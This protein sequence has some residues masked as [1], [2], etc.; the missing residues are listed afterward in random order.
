M[1]LK[2]HLHGD[3]E[4]AG[5]LLHALCMQ[6]SPQAPQVY[7]AVSPLPL[8]CPFLVSVSF[9]P[10]SPTHRVAEPALM[11]LERR[12]QFEGLKKETV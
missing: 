9:A 1:G 10:H 11:R 12:R 2:R 3:R 6:L 5:G 7:A 8:C 4:T